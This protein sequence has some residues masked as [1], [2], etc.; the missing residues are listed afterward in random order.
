MMVKQ[1][2]KPCLEV[3]MV[4]DHQQHIINLQRQVMNLQMKECLPP[5]H[6]HTEIQQQI[7]TLI[8]NWDKARGRRAAA[9]TNDST[10]PD[11]PSL[12]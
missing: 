9:G 10:R 2:S 3:Q 7:H 1:Y 4:Y 5:Q 12:G 11:G 8:I 6:H